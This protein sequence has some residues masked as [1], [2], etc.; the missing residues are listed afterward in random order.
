M[1]CPYSLDKAKEGL[2]PSFKH[3]LNR[4]IKQV[5]ELP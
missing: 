5:K 1:M 2:Y 3:L 4:G